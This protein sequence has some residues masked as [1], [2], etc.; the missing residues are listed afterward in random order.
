MP[1]PLAERLL[2]SGVAPR[3]VWRI[4]RELEDHHC[5]LSEQLRA[6]GHP[7][8]DAES[9]ARLRLGD[10]E[11]LVEQILAQPELRSR[12]RR[13]A[14][15]LFGVA[16]PVATVFLGITVYFIALLMGGIDFQ[17]RELQPHAAAM[18]TAQTLLKW[19]VPAAVGVFLC[20]IALTRR[21]PLHWPVIGIVLTT[22]AASGLHVGPNLIAIGAPPI[23]AGRGLTLFT[24]LM[25]GYLLARGTLERARRAAG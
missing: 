17:T 2:R 14:W 9:E 12:A 21:L 10:R 7:Q 16:P 19:A 22:L 24:V 3:H 13:F 25:L 11:R 18:T 6:D 8:G 4:L 15:L 23:G 20:F 5:D 1:D